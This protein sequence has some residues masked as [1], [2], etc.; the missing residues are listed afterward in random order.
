MPCITYETPEEIAADKKR[1]QND[2]NRRD[3]KEIN[4]LTDMLC[5][6]LTFTDGFPS[7]KKIQDWWI[8]HQKR[9]KMRLAKEAALAKLTKQ[10]K[11][12]LGIKE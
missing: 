2:T 5:T 4:S 8:D 11:E 9:D 12:I 1:S 7:N 6:V 3:K 10:E